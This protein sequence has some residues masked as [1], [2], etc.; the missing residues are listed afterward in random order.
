ML[1]NAELPCYDQVL[2]AEEP[3]R[4]S[5]LVRVL[6]YVGFIAVLAG[7]LAYLYGEGAFDSFV[8]ARTGAT[9]YESAAK[10]VIAAIRDGG[11]DRRDR[12]DGGAQ[13]ARNLRIIAEM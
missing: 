6:S 7:G 9:M 2:E 1:K 8:G 12:D 10:R 11:L 13:L 5:V 4:G 3:V